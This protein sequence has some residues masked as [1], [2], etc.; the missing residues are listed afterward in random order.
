MD[1]GR[2]RSRLNMFRHLHEI[3]SGRTSSISHEVLGFDAR[4]GVINYSEAVTAEEICENSSK[5]VTF[6]GK[7]KPVERKKILFTTVVVIV[8]VV[9]FE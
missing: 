4:G 8:I 9:Y 5:L 3:R 1:N 2:G 7:S 6:L